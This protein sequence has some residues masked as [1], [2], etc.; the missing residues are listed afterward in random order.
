MGYVV[1]LVAV[2]EVV[3]GQCVDGV[4]ARPAGQEFGVVASLDAVVTGAAVHDVGIAC[5]RRCGGLGGVEGVV[6]ARPNAR[7]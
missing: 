6:L 1:S 5:S 7:R 3:A 4:G 2:D